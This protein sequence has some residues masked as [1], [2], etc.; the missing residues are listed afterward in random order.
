MGKYAIG[1]G[2]ALCALSVLPL[3][4]ETGKWSPTSLIPTF[5]GLP[6]IICGVLAAQEKLRK[7]AMHAAAGL[8]LLGM[9]ASAGR[10]ISVMFKPD[11]KF[12]LASFSVWTMAVLCG[13]FLVLCV[14]SFIQAR[15]NREASAS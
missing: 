4:L 1:F 3:F 15:R 7:H 12:G 5:V 9:L 2:V 11:F 13:I 10:G 6:L 8:S 14:R